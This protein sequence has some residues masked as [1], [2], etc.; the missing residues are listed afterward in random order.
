MFPA[1]TFDTETTGKYPES[2]RIVSIAAILDDD[3]GEERAAFNLIVRPE[4]YEIPAEAA[5]IHGI[6]TEIATAVGVPLVVALAT[7]NHL[8]RAA[9]VVV[10]HNIEYDLKVVRSEATR[11][12][13]ADSLAV[14]ALSTFCT[15]E[16]ADPL[17]QM[18][19][20]DRM[21]RAGYG[22]KTK[23]PTLTETIRFFFDEDLDG[24]HGAM[25]DARAARRL[26]HLA[27][28]PHRSAAE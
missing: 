16:W 24:A 27:K 26:Y 17:M 9:L 11:I 19:A 8:C 10:G 25:P 2:A 1:L 20:T 7:F 4:G 15:K 12:R 22:W 28:P 14:D 5:A 21:V 13:R 6:T 23:P 18:A 3:R